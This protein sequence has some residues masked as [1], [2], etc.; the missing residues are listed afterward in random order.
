[1]RL[2]LILVVIAVS[3]ALSRGASAQPAPAV[4]QK[5]LLLAFG[6]CLRQQAPQPVWRT[7]QALAPDLLVLGGDNVYSDVGSYLLRHEPARIGSAYAELAANADWTALRAQVPVYATW[8]DHDYGRNDGGA[9]Y[10]YKAASKD[11]FMSF[12][13]IAPESAMRNRE[14]IYDAHRITHDGRRIQLLLLDT[15]TF[16]SPLVAAGTDADCPRRRW[17]QNTAPE[18]TMLGAAQWAWLAARLQE[19][20]DLHLLVSSIQVIPDAHCYEKWAN[21]PQERARLLK[22]IDG[23]SAPVLILSGDRHLGEI[24]R[25]PENA[26]RHWPLLELTSSGLNSAGAGAGERNRY[27]ALDRN[28]RV[29]NFATLEIRRSGASTEVGL[30]LRASEDAQVLQRLEARFPDRR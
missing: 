21:F 20:A 7:L 9:D 15:R 23:A 8:D 3:L 4:A 12:F 26:A 25:L 13:G 17:G 30:A 18:A 27:R 16:R 5:P 24:S 14:G 6:S 11:Y 2:H 28:V 22:E 10:P 1:M 29:D 19:P